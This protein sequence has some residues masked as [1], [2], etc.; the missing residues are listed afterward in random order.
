VLL[1]LP[2]EETKSNCVVI[3]LLELLIPLY[4]QERIT[5]RQ[6]SGRILFLGPYFATSSVSVEGTQIAP[7]KEFGADLLLCPSC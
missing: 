4:F 7:H 2:T 6:G 5:V 3:G 1:Q